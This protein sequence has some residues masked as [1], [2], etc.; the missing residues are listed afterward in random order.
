[1]NRYRVLIIGVGSI[2]E[3]HLRCFGSTGRADMSFCEINA[4][5]RGEIAK[6]YDIEHTYDDLQAALAEPHDAAVICAPAHLH[7]PMAIQIA[8]AGLHVLIEKPLS[9]SLQDID[10]LQTVLAERRLVAAVAYV[11]RA[12]PTLQAV[13]A[14]LESGRFG[15]PRQM[16][17]VAGQSYPTYRP[18]YRKLYYANHAT[19]GGAIQDALTHGL[20]LGEYLFGPIEHLAADADHQVLPGVTVEDTVNVIA[21]HGQ[22]MASYSLNQFQAPNE[23]LL[24]I[25]CDQGT[26]HANIIEQSWKWIT[27]PG[28][29]W[30]EEPA[31]PFERDKLFVDQ[32]EAFLDAMAGKGQPLCSLAQGIQT[33]RV[34]LAALEAARS[35]TWQ[36]IAQDA[37]PGA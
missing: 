7:V 4:Q 11:M 36:S 10:R 2:G 26:V 13:K 22:V 21:R 14:A 23:M 24:T 30:Q 18:T 8:T 9:T 15:T 5:L 25:A 35:R 16:T 34:N 29:N 37:L 33:L 1:L 19:G 28:G 6:R 20:N 12:H 31:Q 3:R 27:K 17:I 32:A